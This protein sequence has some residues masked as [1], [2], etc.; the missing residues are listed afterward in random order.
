MITHGLEIQ[1][2]SKCS[3]QPELGLVGGG[4]EV[5]KPIRDLVPAMIG[6][7]SSSGSKL[8]PWTCVIFIPGSVFTPVAA[9]VHLQHA[10]EMCLSFPTSQANSSLSPPVFSQFL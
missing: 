4:V 7:S 2:I 10:L 6:T 8:L 9:P 3:S 1:E 5:E